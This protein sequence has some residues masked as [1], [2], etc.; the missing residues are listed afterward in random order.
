MAVT[1]SHSSQC[2]HKQAIVYIFARDEQFKL[3]VFYFFHF[4]KTC[5]FGLFK[6][7]HG[8]QTALKY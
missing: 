8:A 7:T 4:D 5:Y 2:L 3:L 6:D 1:Y